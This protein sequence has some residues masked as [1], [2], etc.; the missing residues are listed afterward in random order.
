MGLQVIP[1]PNEVVSH[2]L[3]FPFP[4]LCFILIH[5]GFGILGP[6]GNPIPMHISTSAKADVMRSVLSVCRSLS[7]CLSVCLSV[8]RITAKVMSR[9]HGSLV[10]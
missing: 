4:I 8:S 10:F 3:P 9:C 2:S 7:V 1:I 5:M 6:I